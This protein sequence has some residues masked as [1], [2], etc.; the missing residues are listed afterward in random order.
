MI[1]VAPEERVELPEGE[2]W[3][4]SLV[5]LDVIDDDSGERL[6]VVVEII[7]TGGNDVYRIVTGGG[8]IKLIPA[9]AGVIREISLEKGTIRVNLLEGLWD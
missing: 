9:I 7:K 2:Y 3:I 4:D 6:G 1:T 5:G 8:E